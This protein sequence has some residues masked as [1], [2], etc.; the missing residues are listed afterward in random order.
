MALQQTSARRLQPQF[1][2][3]E[4]LRATL[5]HI[6]AQRIGAGRQRLDSLREL[7]AALS[8]EATLRR[9]Y[10]I[11]RVDGRAVTSATDVAAGQTIVTTL[12]SGTITSTVN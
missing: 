1:M 6:P 11:T 7:L 9:G 12:A 2:R 8:P 5:A 3:L 4:S 10:S